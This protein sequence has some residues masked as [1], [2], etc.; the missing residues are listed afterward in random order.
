M[1]KNNKSTEETLDNGNEIT[2]DRNKSYEDGSE[3]YTT[4]DCGYS[5][6][7]TEKLIDYMNDNN[8]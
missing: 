2:V 4:K 8:D 6:S 1:G 7:S 5:F 3:Y